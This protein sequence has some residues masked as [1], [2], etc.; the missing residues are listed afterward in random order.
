MGTSMGTYLCVVDH[1]QIASRGYMT[2]FF[3]GTTPLFSSGYIHVGWYILLACKTPL[4]AV[5]V[6]FDHYSSCS[7]VEA[8]G[9]SWFVLSNNIQ[10]TRGHVRRP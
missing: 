5:V 2:T 1:N 9:L 3:I 6:G 10:E 4:P 7:Y 8:L